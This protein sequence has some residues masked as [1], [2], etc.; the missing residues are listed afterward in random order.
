MRTRIMLFL[1]VSA[2]LRFDAAMNAQPVATIPHNERWLDS[3]TTPEFVA[4]E[5]WAEWKVKRQAVR[6]T[7]EKMLG[8]FPPRPTVPQV[9]VLSREERD[10]YILEKFRFENGLGMT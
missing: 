8:D 4:P 9:T 2:T 10:G 7:L 6:A 3:L 1:A 5:T